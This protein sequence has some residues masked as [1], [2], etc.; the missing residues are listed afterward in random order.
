MRP[1][2]GGH[3]APVCECWL[4]RGKAFQVSAR[5]ASPWAAGVGS[6]PTRGEL[7]I[8][9]PRGQPVLDV[10][11][12]TGKGSDGQTYAGLCAV[13]YINKIQVKQFLLQAVLF[14]QGLPVTWLPK[15]RSPP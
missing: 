5:T 4:L 13:I 11:L 2:V 8:H 14:Q 6:T 1:C 15:Q 10:P 12:G 9:W 7:P 3:S